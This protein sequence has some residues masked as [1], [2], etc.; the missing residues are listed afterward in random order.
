M[1]Y[2]TVTIFAVLVLGIVSSSSIPARGQGNTSTQPHLSVQPLADSEIFSGAGAAFT[3]VNPDGSETEAFFGY[4]DPSV[5]VNLRVNHTLYKVKQIS[6]K[7]VSKGR[8]KGSLGARTIEIW[9][10]GQITLELDYTVSVEGEGGVGYKGKAT[11]KLGG[12]Q[13]S[14]K[15]RGGAG[16]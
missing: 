3:L 8:G 6:S 7:E 10:N 15:I 5:E 4:D 13:S 9:G 12:K 1:R 11:V 14:F 2:L 16:C